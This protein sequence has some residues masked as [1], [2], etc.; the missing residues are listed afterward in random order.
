[1]KK[2]RKLLAV[3]MTLAMVMGLGM[4]SF[5]AEKTTATITVENASSVV[6]DANGLFEVVVYNTVLYELPSTGGLGIYVPMM[7]GV[8]MMMAAAFI[9]MNNKR[10][11]VL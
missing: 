11:E 8:I 6:A 7:S 4:T 1:M 5:A 2:M 10:K 3:L 9:L